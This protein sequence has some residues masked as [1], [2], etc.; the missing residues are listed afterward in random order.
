MGRVKTQ[1]LRLKMKLRLKPKV[2]WGGAR[3]GAGRPRKDGT[4]ASKPGVKHRVRPLLATR[5]PVHVTWRINRQVWSL[6]FPRLFRVLQSVMYAGAKKDFRVVHYAFQKDHIHLIVEASDRKALSRG[7]Q[8][9]GVRVAKA[10]N[11]LMRRSGNVVPDRYHANILLNPTMVRN[12][13]RYLLNNAFKH[14]R[15]VGPDPFASQRPVTAPHTWLLKR[16]E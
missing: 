4:K 8:G 2:G 13:R 14:Y 5:F 10:V 1:Q 3:K 6:R 15:I 16:Q 12:A 9:L 7:M 11:F